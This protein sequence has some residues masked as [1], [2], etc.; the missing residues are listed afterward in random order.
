MDQIENEKT[1]PSIIVTC[2]TITATWHNVSLTRGIF[3]I[4]LKIKKK[5]QNKKIKKNKNHSKNLETDTWHPFNTVTTP[6]TEK[7]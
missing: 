4:F 2:D 6:L 5:I 7:T 3:F 1:T